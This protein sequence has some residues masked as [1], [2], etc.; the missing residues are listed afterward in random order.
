MYDT[1]WNLK[2]SMTWKMSA[3]SI[4]LPQI[5]AVLSS[6]HSHPNMDTFFTRS[7]EAEGLKHAYTMSLQRWYTS[8]CSM[9]GQR[10]QLANFF[11]YSYLL[12]HFYHSNGWGH[13][14]KRWGDSKFSR[15]NMSIFKALSQTRSRES[16]QKPWQFLVKNYFSIWFSR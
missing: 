14:N 8:I 12:T 10:R 13:T 9:P 15:P 11:K 16:W 1:S 3:L 5:L 6:V 4:I 7:A 2:P